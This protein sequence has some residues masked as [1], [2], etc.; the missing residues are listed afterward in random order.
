MSRAASGLLPGCVYTGE[1]KEQRTRTCVG[2]AGGA[3]MAP[4]LTNFL[5]EPFQ[6]SVSTRLERRVQVE[7]V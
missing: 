1:G 5:L 3:S 6:G 2:S 4:Y 7:Q